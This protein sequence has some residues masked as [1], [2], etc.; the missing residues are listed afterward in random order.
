[1]TYIVQHFITYLEIFS[2]EEVL[3][4]LLLL[5]EKQDQYRVLT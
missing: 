4:W 1:M 3:E 5:S 2:L